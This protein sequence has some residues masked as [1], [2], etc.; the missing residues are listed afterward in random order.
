MILLLIGQRGFAGKRL[1][2]EEQAEERGADGQRVVQQSQVR[3]GDQ[4]QGDAQ[5]RK[6]EEDVFERWHRNQVFVLL[7]SLRGNDP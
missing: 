6:G 2:D 5:G 4:S 7:T 1:D 3:G